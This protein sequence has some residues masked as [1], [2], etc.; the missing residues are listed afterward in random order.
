MIILA[1][2]IPLGLDAADLTERRPTARSWLVVDALTGTPLRYNRTREVRPIASTTKLLTALLVIRHGG[3][4]DWV[5]ISANAAA[6]P[7]SKLG[8]R[9]GE[10]FRRRDLLHALLMQSANDAATALAESVSGTERAFCL[11]A[12]AHAR[13][14]GCASTTI[15]RASGLP[16]NGQGSTARDLDI[17]AAA[18]LENRLIEKICDTTE[19]TIRSQGGRACR[20]VNKNRLHDDRDE[21]LGKTG[22][23]RRAQRC[24]AGE[25]ELAGR[26]H[27]IV[28]LGSKDLWGDLRLLR[29]WTKKFAEALNRNRKVLT[30]DQ[31]R[32]WQRKL[33]RAGLDP[34]PADGIWGARTQM[35]YLRWEQKRGGRP[36]GVVR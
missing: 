36:D 32:S 28:L 34:G 27:R 20:V 30:G 1:G 24:F 8:L 18:A 6:Q 2:M 17:I 35:A 26:P 11:Q 13:Q 15:L 31:V 19:V 4:D 14:L 21:V 23:T 29:D 25:M 9:E 12:T 10:R 5:R 3:L 16:R 33:D 22:Y 7:P